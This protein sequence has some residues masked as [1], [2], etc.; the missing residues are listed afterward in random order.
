VEYLMVLADN[1]WSISEIEQ[2]VA[3]RHLNK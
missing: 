1:Q 2:G 3:W